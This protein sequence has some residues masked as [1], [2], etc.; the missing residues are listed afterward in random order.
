METVPNLETVYQGIH[1]L[2]ND[3]QPSAQQKAAKWLEEVQKSVKRKE[4]TK[5]LVGH[6]SHRL[7]L[8][9]HSGLLVEDRR[10]DPA[11]ASGHRVMLVRRTDDAQ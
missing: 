7:L 5:P 6:Q 11:A 3:P 9:S 10:R 2:Y 8:L 4:E 1:T